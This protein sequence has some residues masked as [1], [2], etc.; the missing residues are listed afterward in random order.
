[1]TGLRIHARLLLDAA[2]KAFLQLQNQLSAAP[3][4]SF[5]RADLK[6]VLITNARSR[7]TELPRG[8]SA[9]LIETDMDRQV[10]VISHASCQLKEKKNYSLFLLET[11][12]A[13]WITSMK[14]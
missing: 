4:L 6:Y 3:V 8:L 14:T 9:T 10:H 5:P 1:M 11:V 13:A 2:R 7:T 12:A